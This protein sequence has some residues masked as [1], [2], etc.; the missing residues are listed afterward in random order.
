MSITVTLCDGVADMGE[1]AT[2]EDAASWI[3]YA[4]ERLHAMYPGITVATS[5]DDGTRVSADGEEAESVRGAVQDIWETWCARG[6]G[7]GNGP[8]AQIIPLRAVQS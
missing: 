1:N 6:R 2:E 5:H 3:T 7:E 8:N 4:T